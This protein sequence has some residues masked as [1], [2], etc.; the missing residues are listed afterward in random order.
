LALAA[1]A[2]LPARRG[3]VLTLVSAAAIG[4]VVVLAGSPA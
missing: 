3:V 4:T 1:I 2:L